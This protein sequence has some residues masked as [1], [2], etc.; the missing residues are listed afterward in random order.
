MPQLI[1]GD[2]LAVF[3]TGS[4]RCSRLTIPGLQLFLKLKQHSVSGAVLHGSGKL[5][6]PVHGFFK[7]FRHP[8]HSNTRA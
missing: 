7:Q 6:Q 4:T 1:D 5:S 3:E 2:K 8:D